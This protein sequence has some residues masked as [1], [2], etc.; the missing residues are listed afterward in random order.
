MPVC[1][2]TQVLNYLW[3]HIRKR[4][5]L[6]VPELNKD[7]NGISRQVV[8]KCAPEE[9]IRCKEVRGEGG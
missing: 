7:M 1:N 5:S 8:T 9:K 4:D 6:Q 2:V 3:T